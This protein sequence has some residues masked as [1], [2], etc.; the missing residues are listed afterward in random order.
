MCLVF[1][2][3]RLVA[4]NKPP[5][6]SVAT[7]RNDPGAAVVRLV[8]MISP[9]E[10]ES[11]GIEPQSLWLVHRLDVG[12]SGLVLLA[13]DP[14]HHRSL[15]RALSEHQIEKTYLALVWGTPRP[16]AGTYTWPLA[17]DTRDRRRMRVE[18]RGKTAS[19][20]YRVLASAPHVSLAELRP[21][22]GRTHQLRVHLAHAGHPVV[23]D[24]LY[25]GPRHRGVRDPELRRRLEPGHTFLHAWRLSLPALGGEPPL[26]LTAL[27]PED[28]ARALTALGGRVAEA[29][30][31]AGLVQGE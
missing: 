31:D 15:V 26:V 24:D 19:S 4:L 25:G 6:L 21:H 1:S 17:P 11:W 20:A 13:R 2:D 5:G 16:A 23:G 3:H 28:F 9:G 29:A 14:E 30:R 18:E 8:E 22:T 12:T 27:L 10:R 7:P